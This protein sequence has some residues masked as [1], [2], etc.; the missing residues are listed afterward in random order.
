M[1]QSGNDKGKM[2]VVFFLFFFFL[3]PRFFYGSII[4]RFGK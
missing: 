2:T 3:L 4:D 1:T